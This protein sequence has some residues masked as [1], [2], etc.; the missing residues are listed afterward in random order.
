MQVKQQQSQNNAAVDLGDQIISGGPPRTGA[1]AADPAVSAGDALISQTL[2]GVQGAREAPAST[3]NTHEPSMSLPP[4]QPN[5]QTGATDTMA[6]GL[7]SFIQE[8]PNYTYGT[9]LPLARNNETGKLSLAVP[10]AI[11]DLA[12]GLLDLAE[13]PATG[14]VTPQG[15]MALTNMLTQSPRLFGS[16][17]SP[18]A[19]A[20]R[21]PDVAAPFSPEYQ[22]FRETLG[23]KTMTPTEDPSDAGTGK[24][25][26]LLH[27]L[28]ARQIGRSAGAMLGH[29]LGNVPGAIVGY[30]LEP[31]L[32]GLAADYGQK[33]ASAVVQSMKNKYKGFMP[34]NYMWRAAPTVQQPNQNPLVD[35]RP[36][37]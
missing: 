12:G 34:E 19:N 27:S 1:A 35:N 13:G 18:A 3:S 11:H 33:A 32:Q 26:D 31:Y 23:P 28:I 9:V 22:A 14:T 10:G 6:P 4:P 30:M 7:R 16:P 25:A 37:A 29:T 2:Q 5:P 21:A 17:A 20:M 8:N 36:L 15:T 24:V